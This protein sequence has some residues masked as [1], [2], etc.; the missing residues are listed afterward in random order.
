MNNYVLEFD[1]QNVTGVFKITD[2][3]LEENMINNPKVD[4][5]YEENYLKALLQDYMERIV[6]RK[7]KWII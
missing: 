5:S 2:Y 7:L 6:E 4:Y 3:F 1:G